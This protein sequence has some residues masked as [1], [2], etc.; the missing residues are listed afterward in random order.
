MKRHFRLWI[1]VLLASA[2]A[3][4][5]ACAEEPTAAAQSQAPATNPDQV[6][7]E[8]AGKSITLKEVDAKWEAFDA[9]ERARI[10][11]AMYQNRRNMIDLLVGDQLIANAAKASGQSVE[12]FLEADGAKR[13]PA[14]SEADIAQFYEQNKERAQGRT[15]DQLRLEIKPYLEGR[16][17][18]QARAMLVEELK[19]KDGANVKVMLD[20]PRYTVPT[21]PDDPVRGNAA[22]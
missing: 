21:A 19:S 5:G 15:L 4:A 6:V 17:R 14:V 1:G 16:R 8:V 18:Q 12:A 2:A 3:L 22:A 7:A 13:L 11:Q 9:A 10:V 20:P